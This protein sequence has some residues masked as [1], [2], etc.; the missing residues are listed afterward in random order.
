MFGAQEY[1]Q[2]VVVH[3]REKK[4]RLL[5]K[6]QEAIRLG[7]QPEEITQADLERERTYFRRP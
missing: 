4:Q 5:A 1:T 2:L 3:K 6:Q 7:E